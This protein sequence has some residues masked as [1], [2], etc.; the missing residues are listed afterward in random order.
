MTAQQRFSLPLLLCISICKSKSFVL[1]IVPRV[2]CFVLAT[3]F[4]CYSEH[5]K[6]LGSFNCKAQSAA[7][8]GIKLC[9]NPTIIA[10][11]LLASVGL[12]LKEILSL[13]SINIYDSNQAE[14]VKSKLNT[15][16]TGSEHG[17]TGKKTCQHPS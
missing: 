14:L 17:Q 7:P 15:T 6:G 1:L 4:L 5:G 8:L 11:F 13:F 12:V 2:L 10:L 16:R 9:I 3:C